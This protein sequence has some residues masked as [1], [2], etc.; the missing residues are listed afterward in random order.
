MKFFYY[1]YIYIYIERERERE[2]EREAKLNTR[3]SLIAQV[4]PI[5]KETVYQ[6]DK[7]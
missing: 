2:R 4:L 7:C 6:S 5:F 1:I 3:W